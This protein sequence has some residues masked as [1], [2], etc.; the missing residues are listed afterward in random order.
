MD[1]LP[2]GGAYMPLRCRV[3]ARLMAEAIT[4]MSTCKESVC[5]CMIGRRGGR[6]ETHMNAH[7]S[8][9]SP[10]HT[11]M[12]MQIH[13]HTHTN[14]PRQPLGWDALRCQEPGFLD[15]QSPFEQLLAC[16]PLL[17]LFLQTSTPPT[18]PPP[19][20][21]PQPPPSFTHSTSKQA[22]AG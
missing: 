6:E 10:S 17:C 4:L 13:T 20:P 21:T 9:F 3:S 1:V 7:T 22:R 5:E 18:P 19:P 16:R 11:H 12:H 14:E 2:G 8:S 15:H